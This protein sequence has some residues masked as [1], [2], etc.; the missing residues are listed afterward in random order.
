MDNIIKPVTIDFRK[1]GYQDLY[2]WITEESNQR[3]DGKLSATILDM[4]KE[5]RQRREF[6][7]GTYSVIET[8]SGRTVTTILPPS[9]K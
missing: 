1:K 6:P 4:L 9:T 3:N 8:L 5:L 7:E 2:A